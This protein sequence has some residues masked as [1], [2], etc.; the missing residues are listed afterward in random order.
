[1]SSKREKAGIRKPREKRR[2][3]ET[4]SASGRGRTGISKKKESET[5]H[6]IT[7]KRNEGG[8]KTSLFFTI[9]VTQRGR[10]KD[11]LRTRGGLIL[12]RSM[13]EGTEAWRGGGDVANIEEKG[14][15][16]GS[17]HPR[18]KTGVV[19]RKRGGGEVFGD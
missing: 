15:K 16:K 7:K 3:P 18:K 5:P 9:K 8:K 6:L 1:V 11:F 12:K 13:G 17:T 14:K 10:K 19:K 2:E 4:N